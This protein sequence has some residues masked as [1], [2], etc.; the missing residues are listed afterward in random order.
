MSD[1]KPRTEA[2]REKTT[3][4]AP[5]KPPSTLDAPQLQRVLCIVGSVHLLWVLMM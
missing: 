5:W 4:R 3:R 2:T 1:R